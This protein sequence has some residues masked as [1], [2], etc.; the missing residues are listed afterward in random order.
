MLFYYRH[1]K[2]VFLA[3]GIVLTPWSLGTT[4]ADA[5]GTPLDIKQLLLQKLTRMFSPNSVGM[6]SPLKSGIT[7]NE[8]KDARQYIDELILLK[9]VLL[10]NTLYIESNLPL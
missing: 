4:A 2:T 1:S 6:Y 7:L 3:Q 9:L 8:F 5:L 10:W